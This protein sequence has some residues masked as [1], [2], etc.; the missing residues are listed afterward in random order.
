MKELQFTSPSCRVINDMRNV[1]EEQFREMRSIG[2][3]GSDAGA[4]M[5]LSK[6]KSPMLVVADKLGL[7]DFEGNKATERGK[8]M[9]PVI[10]EN[11]AKWAAEI[12]GNPAETY[13]VFESPY[14]YQS[15]EHPFMLANIDGLVNHREHGMCVLEIKT[16]DIRL[17]TEWADNGVPDSYYAQVQHYMAVLGLDMAI[18]FVLVGLD[19]EI[20]YVARNN[21]FI[22]DMIA[23][24]KNIW[25]NF[26]QSKI[27]PDPS[28]IDRENDLLNE[29]YSSPSQDVIDISAFVDKAA[30]HVE[31]KN[32]IDELSKERDELTGFFKAQ[33]KDAKR[34]TMPGY[35]ATWSRF[36]SKYFDKGALERDD[37][38]LV[39][40]YTSEKDSGRF[41]LSKKEE[42]KK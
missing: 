16:A 18:V 33:L 28:G 30:R 26:V 13:E 21:E 42:P 41:L 25:T 27:L 2:I 37:P 19:P 10:R 4:I 15:I 12:D 23:A 34:G 38:K 22:A 17:E 29:L 31:L 20:R 3:G 32:M 40:K 6:Y 36:K 8:R 24:E 7:T 35:V 14:Q 5:G 1:S 39:A 11:F 9:E